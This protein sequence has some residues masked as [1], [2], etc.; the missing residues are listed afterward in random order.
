[1]KCQIC[2]MNEAE[3][4]KQYI[5]DHRPTYSLPGSHYRGFIVVKVCNECKELEQARNAKLDAVRDAA[6]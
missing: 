3:W 2:Q 4:S 6:K 5:N 1:M